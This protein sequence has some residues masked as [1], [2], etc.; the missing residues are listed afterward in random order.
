M[1]F[2]FLT[3]NRKTHHIVIAKTSKGS[4]AYLPSKFGRF[5][6]AALL[7][8][9]QAN[10]MSQMTINQD[11]YI[12]PGAQM[13][14]VL[15]KTVFESGV[16]LADRGNGTNYGLLS[17]GAQSTVEKADHNTHVNGFVR[18]QNR[19]NFVYPIGHDN[20]L[21]PVHFKSDNSDAQ[22][23]FA[24]SHTPHTTLT[25]ENAL[26]KVSDE[27]YWTIKGKGSSR[28]YL[29]WNTFSNLDRLTDNKLENLTI[30][31]FD[32]NQWINIPAQIDEVS[33]QEGST[34]T[35]LSGSI[36][37]IDFIDPER[38]SAFTLG[39]K[40]STESLYDFKASEA[41]TPNGDGVN[42]TWFVEDIIDHPNSEVKV[43]NRLGQLVFE[44]KGY[45]NDW[46]GNYKNNSETLPEA[47]YFFTIDLDGDGTVD[48]TGWLYITK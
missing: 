23:D 30:A 24:Y 34:P 22:L 26:Q 4:E 9:S 39:R 46:R 40:N 41:I 7:F 1:S 19:Q 36:S 42:D 11:V 44:A 31:A 47:S 18:S 45:Q 20:I 13:H 27:F 8:W 33:F 35:L 43:F 38:Y 2:S 14:T 6:L 12:A 21:Q 37:S 48:K 29:S 32:G 10:L 16:V 28:I 3:L 15:P 17:F 5:F 25:V